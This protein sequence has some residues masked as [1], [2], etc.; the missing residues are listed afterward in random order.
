MEGCDGTSVFVLTKSDF[1][2]PLSLLYE[3]PYSEVA[4]IDWW[5][6]SIVTKDCAR[7]GFIKNA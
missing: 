4:S 7:F 5:R 6:L 2:Y 3:S 1:D